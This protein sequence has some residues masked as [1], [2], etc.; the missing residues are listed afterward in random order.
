LAPLGYSDEPP[1]PAF[2]QVAGPEL[3]V[4]AT[5]HAT[6]EQLGGLPALAFT[7]RPRG[8][9]L[10][11]EAEDSQP[12]IGPGQYPHGSWWDGYPRGWVPT[13]SVAITGAAFA[14]AMGRQSLGTTNAL[15]VAFN[16]RLGCWIPNPALWHAFA[17]DPDHAPRVHIGYLVKE[18]FG[19]YHPNRDPFIYVADGGHRD[20]LG[21]VEQLRERPK[22]VFVIDASGDTPGKFTTLKQAIELADV[23]L[24]IIVTIDEPEWANILHPPDGLP[25][26]CVAKGTIRYPDGSPDGT[27][28]YGRHQVSVT[29]SEPIRH[30]AAEN[31]K[32]PNYS[33]GNQ[34]LSDAE[35]EHLV[36]LGTE[37]GTRLRLRFEGP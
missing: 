7:F 20:N 36:A 24:G 29:S 1:W 23:E 25:K 30:F 16:I 34:F 4:C 3:V 18:L 13:R 22:S 12:F 10:Y 8:V 6:R 37:V 5:A 35:F 33:T 21:F 27:L 9:T 14:S 2:D 31:P 28:Y 11:N 26:D 32:F 15:L 17:D 19:S